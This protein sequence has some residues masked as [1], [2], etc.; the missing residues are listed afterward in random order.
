VSTRAEAH[1]DRFNVAVSSGEW[2]S[3]VVGFTDAATMRFVGVPVPP[4]EGREAIL[5]QYRAQPPSDTMRV[6][7]VAFDG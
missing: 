7:E 6:L 1:V 2:E 4:A 5:A 3:F